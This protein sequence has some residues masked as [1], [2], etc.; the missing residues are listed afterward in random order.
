MAVEFGLTPSSRT[1]LAAGFAAGKMTPPGA[2]VDDDEQFFG[3]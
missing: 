2:S 3:F 1:R